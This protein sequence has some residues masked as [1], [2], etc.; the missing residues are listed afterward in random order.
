MKR[1]TAILLGVLVLCLAGAVYLTRGEI[2][3]DLFSLP[4]AGGELSKRNPLD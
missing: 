1:G 4:A 2:S 3:G